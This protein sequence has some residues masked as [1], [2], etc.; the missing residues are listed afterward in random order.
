MTQSSSTH[1][2]S[3][4]AAVR[5]VTGREISTRV[6][7]K[8]YKITTVVMLLAVVGL[9]VALKLIGGAS[10]A[11]AVG[12]TPSVAALAEPLK[13]VSGAV[14]QKV[15]TSTIEQTAG[16]AQI[17]DGSLDALVVGTPENFQVVV[18]KD[19][20]GNLRSAFTV[21]ARQM[22]LNGE[23]TRVGGDPAAVTAAVNAA[24][25]DV[26]ALEP[27]TQFQ[28]ER[29]V[30]GIIVSVIVYVAVML[31]GQMVAQGVVEEKSSRIVEML[32]T[33][34]RPWQLMLGKVAGIGV[35]GLAQLALVAIAGVGAGLTAGTVDFPASLAAGAAGW[36][37]TWF[38]LGFLLYALMFAALGA[39][40][41]RQEDVGGVTAPIL[42]LIIV[43]YV[44]G[45]S[46]LPADP[47]NQALA[48]ASIIPF[49]APMLMPMRIALGVAP[50]WQ[51]AVA[52]VLT[53]LLIVFMV[54]LAGRIYRNAVVRTGTRVKITHALRNT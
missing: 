33:T 34:I 15:T 16:E 32:L 50:V 38:L 19:L 20:G 12:F 35:I 24:T 40:V 27:S 31:Y 41:S 23:I 28:T 4:F 37:V 9:I 22:A 8:A 21:L 2:L 42:M 26:Q 44:A 13:A 39:L 45:I 5:L 7:S 6:R 30:I 10:A 48:I 36:A 52:V 17:R 43:P 51:V 18:K 46:I 47:E 49:F 1:D 3:P 54:W 14:D 25:V 29:L 53:M 11:S